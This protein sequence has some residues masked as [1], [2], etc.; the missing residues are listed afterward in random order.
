MAMLQ[1]S[2]QKHGQS[3]VEVMVAL[4]IVMIVLSSSIT[5]IITVLNA[6]VNTRVMTEATTLAQRGLSEGYYRTTC[7]C[8][9]I[10]L[11]AIS[12][13]DA[14]LN[15]NDGTQPLSVYSS[16]AD[17]GGSPQ[18][19]P[20]PDNLHLDVSL[21][22]LH[23]SDEIDDTIGLSSTNFYRLVSKVWWYDKNSNQQT[24]SLVKLVPIGDNSND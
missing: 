6:A 11:S 16:A 7:G 17:M 23:S 22:L 19:D 18:P 9:G 8:N 12:G 2:K 10:N 3:L 5:L 24:Y 20:P 21:Y 14:F 13:S 4:T 15:H 1:F